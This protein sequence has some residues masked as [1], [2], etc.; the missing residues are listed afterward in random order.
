MQFESLVRV[1]RGT[2]KTFYL[3][4]GGAAVEGSGNGRSSSKPKPVLY[5]LDARPFKRLNFAMGLGFFD[6][7]RLSCRDHVPDRIALLTV[8]ECCQMEAELSAPRKR[9][10]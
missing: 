5:A 8:Q 4:L 6:S 2:V 9:V 1:L 7:E 3:R 10:K